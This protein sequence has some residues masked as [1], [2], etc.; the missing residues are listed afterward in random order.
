MANTWASS[1]EINVRAGEVEDNDM[2]VASA[3]MQAQQP[4]QGAVVGMQP[5]MVA[6]GAGGVPGQ[7]GWN[8]GLFV[9]Q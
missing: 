3:V 4:V 2:T 6:P 5:V 7:N 9:S 1:R 8:V